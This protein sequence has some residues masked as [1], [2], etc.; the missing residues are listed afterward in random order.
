MSLEN[1]G[2]NVFPV[3]CGNGIFN[4]TQQLGRRTLNEN[5]LL[6]WLFFWQE[7]NEWVWFFLWVSDECFPRMPL[8]IFL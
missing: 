1:Y 8:L 2:Q 5:S 4:S 7:E 6:W 3:R